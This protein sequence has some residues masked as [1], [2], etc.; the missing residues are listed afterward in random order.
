MANQDIRQY[1][2]EKG[3]RLWQCAAA[4]GISE[5]TMTRKLRTELTEQAKQELIHIIDGLSENAEPAT[6]ELKKESAA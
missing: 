6:D 2:K 1:A 3:V 5:P 4:M